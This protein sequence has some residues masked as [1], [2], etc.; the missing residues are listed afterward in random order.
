MY[1]STHS[2]L[3]AGFDRRAFL[4]TSAAVG[5]GAVASPAIVSNALSSS[6]TLSI[7]NWDD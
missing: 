4:K 2:L 1:K 7:I 5:L 3:L 6:G